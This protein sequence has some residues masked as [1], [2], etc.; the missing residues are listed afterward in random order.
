MKKILMK[1]VLL[2]VVLGGVALSEEKR[3]STNTRALIA[4]N[5]QNREVRV[6]LSEGSILFSE[7][8][9]AC[10]EIKNA[11][12]SKFV[13]K[14]IPGLVITIGKPGKKYEIRYFSFEDTKK[15]LD[16]KMTFGDYIKQRSLIGAKSSLMKNSY[17]IEF[18]V[19]DG[20]K[21][22]LNDGVYF[23]MGLREVK[24]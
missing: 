6:N 8:L 21:F 2:C 11:L 4:A 15:A 23:S 20:P 7:L 9:E 16:L 3:A 22:K 18:E 24:D 14:N 10:P 19:F 5:Q 17:G 12:P 1:I 13:H